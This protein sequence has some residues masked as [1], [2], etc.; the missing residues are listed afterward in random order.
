MVQVNQLLELINNLKAQNL[1]AIGIARNFVSH[2][3]QPLKS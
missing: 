3:I 1:T 2:R